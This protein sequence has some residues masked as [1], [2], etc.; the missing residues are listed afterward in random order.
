MIRRPW[1]VF[2]S[3]PSMIYHFLKFQKSL[4]LFSFWCC[5]L[6]KFLIVAG[7]MEKH[8]TKNA[9]SKFSFNNITSLSEHYLFF[10]SRTMYYNRQCQSTYITIPR[11]F[12]LD[13]M[14]FFLVII[15]TPPIL[16]VFLGYIVVG[17]KYFFNWQLSLGIKKSNRRSKR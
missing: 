16:Y 8:S 5:N 4:I 1:A 12:C 7:L 14:C 6:A 15:S 17:P 13:R 9:Y 11:L 3:L 10:F 2:L